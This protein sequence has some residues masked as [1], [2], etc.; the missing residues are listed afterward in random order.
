MVR[1]DG[2]KALA[3]L[4]PRTT[5]R[6]AL[7]PHEPVEPGPPVEPNGELRTGD[8]FAGHRIEAVAGRGGMGVVY[9]AVALD[10]DRQ[11]AL[12]LIAP[13]LSGDPAFRERFIRETR[14]AASLDHPNVIPVFAAGEEHGR[15][16]FSMRYVD[17]DDLRT[18]IRREG[19]LDPP[20]AAAIVAQI[21][22]A[23]D[24]AHAHGV[25]H[26]DVKPANVLL[27]P[28]PPH[29]HAYLT[30]FGLTKRLHSAAAETR[31]GGWVGTLGYV[32]PEQIR[33]ERVDA[34]A[35]VYALG[36]VL[37]HTLTGTT[38]Y[39][40]ESDEAT[41]WAHLHEPPPALSPRVPDVP[42]AF[43]AV[44]ARAMAKAPAERFASAGDLGRAALAAAGNAPAP[45]SER[46]VATGRAAAADQQTMA[47]GAT[48]PTPAAPTLLAPEV[49]RQ[50]GRR[51]GLLT[52][53]AIALAAVGA[54][55]ALVLATGGDD[56]RPPSRPTPT[57]T[58]GARTPVAGKLTATIPVGRRPNALAVAGDHL[59]VASQ[60]EPRLRLFD[61][62]DNDPVSAS[63]KVGVGATSL[64][65]G[66]DSVWIVKGTTRTLLRYSTRALTRTGPA[67][68]LPPGN[69]I[70]VATAKHAVWVGSR[71]GPEDV[72]EA[73]IRIKVG[74]SSRV[75]SSTTIDDGVQDLTVGEGAVWV[76]GRSQ[77]RVTRIDMATG[78]RK[79]FGVG[80]A[81]QRI[82]VGDGAAWVSN[83]DGYVT[84]IDLRSERIKRI[85]VSRGPRGIAVGDG[86]VWVA[87]SLAGTLTRL[88]PATG[89]VVGR[90]VKVGGNPSAVTV[91]GT[92]AYVSLLADD[93]VARVDFLP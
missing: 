70:A 72:P 74:T 19:R 27:T 32:S 29:G 73:A 50:G 87:A 83:D 35:D 23:L 82:A 4:A 62:L 53:G 31:P 65:V 88:D 18:L 51:P 33:G 92:R 34:R 22:A 68:A 38:P 69:P 1:L 36:C 63:P 91:F 90:P 64:A 21:G 17:G 71:H 55:V 8:L 81:P 85:G 30:D 75:V 10:L 41:L 48:D 39:A 13:S 61:T 60:S 7:P 2:R 77:A 15:L 42:R 57:T 44:I 52:A 28:G 89:D 80:G 3:I 58:T 24:G 12:K 59:W 25:V 46:S 76:I 78:R 54:G 6:C 11:V 93:A 5:G 16:F 9:R 14:V 40:R 79:T 20:R 43:E 49:P 67:T 56:P 26:R 47:S 66:F 45:A 84:R 37:F 86:A